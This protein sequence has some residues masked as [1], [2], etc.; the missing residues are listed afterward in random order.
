MEHKNCTKMV[1]AHFRPHFFGSEQ[2]FMV[3]KY[4]ETG[5]CSGN[6]Q[7]VSKTLKP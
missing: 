1:G 6:N 7:K 2:V 3:L 5:E 4:T